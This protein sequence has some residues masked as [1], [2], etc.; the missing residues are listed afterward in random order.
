MGS[1]TRILQNLLN[2]SCMTYFLVN[3]QKVYNSGST[4]ITCK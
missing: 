1:T 2:G 4:W 3:G